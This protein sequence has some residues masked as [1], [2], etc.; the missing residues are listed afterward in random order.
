MDVEVEVFSRDAK[1][2]GEAKKLRREGYVPCVVYSAGAV[3]E[4]YYIKKVAIDTVIR[5]LEFGFLP[6]TVFVLKNQAGK[7]RRAIVKE[8]QYKV[9]SYDVSHVDFLELIADRK[10]N[11]K[12]PV[13]FQNVI[14]CVGVKAGGFL[15]QVLQHVQVRCLPK[16]IPTHFTIDVKDIDIRQARRVVDIA[17]PK[18]VISLIKPQD[19]VVTVVK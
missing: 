2:K 4:N 15:R 8:I 1:N 7:Q 6:T 3:G 16:D 17:I 9:T 12:V 19:V 11:V 5:E 18:E 13:Q 10:V 14:D